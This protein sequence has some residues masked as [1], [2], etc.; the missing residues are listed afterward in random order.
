MKPSF[1]RERINYAFHLLALGWLFGGTLFLQFIAGLSVFET[2]PDV[3]ENSP[4]DRTA[5]V[6]I[7]NGLSAEQKKALGSALAGAAVGP[8]FPKYFLCS[9]IAATVAL[10]SARG[11]RSKEKLNRIQ[12]GLLVVTF[13]LVCGNWWIAGEVSRLRLERFAA[14]AETAARAKENFTSW[15]LVSLLLSML[16]CLTAT[17]SLICAAW[18]APE[19][20]QMDVGQLP[21]AA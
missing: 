14:D 20:A 5:Q 16:T 17:I 7:A 6:A 9:A 19:K 12:L 13:L 2:F 10:I 8:M 4:S 1:R 18:T 21:K 15:H 11:W 3:V